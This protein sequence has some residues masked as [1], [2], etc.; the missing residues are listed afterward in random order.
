MTSKEAQSITKHAIEIGLLRLAPPQDTLP[1]DLVKRQINAQN[2]L[3]R[4]YGYREKNLAAGLRA[5]GQPRISNRIML[6][7]WTEE[8]KRA[9]R[10]EQQRQWRE[11]Q[12]RL[13]KEQLCEQ[14]PHSP[15]TPPTV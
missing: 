6:I 2:N 15:S 3:K 8:Q 11:K 7:G 10:L 13:Q 14:Q 9:R 12:Y 5:N 1:V 4:Y